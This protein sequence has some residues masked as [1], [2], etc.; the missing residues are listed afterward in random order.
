MAPHEITIL[1]KTERQGCGSRCQTMSRQRGLPR[2]AP[3]LL[4]L[5]FMSQAVQIT[6]ICPSARGTK[7]RFIGL[8]SSRIAQMPQKQQSKPLN[9]PVNRLVS[10]REVFRK[11]HVSRKRKL[12]YLESQGTYNQTKTLPITQL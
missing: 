9:S 6:T 11:A 3:L 12:H 2:F 7:Y 1:Q 5:S 8:P 10:L 4:L